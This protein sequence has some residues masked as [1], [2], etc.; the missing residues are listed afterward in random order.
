MYVRMYICSHIM[1]CSTTGSLLI[2]N[3]LLLFTK[4]YSM[5]QDNYCV[6]VTYMYAKFF[7]TSA[8]PLVI[9]AYLGCTTKFLS[10]RPNSMF[11]IKI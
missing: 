1:H 4:G 2:H 6:G 9:E 5:K 8:Q 7:A 3:L 10:R 11:F